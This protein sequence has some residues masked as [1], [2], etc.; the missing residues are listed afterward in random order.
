MNFDN[1]ARELI[2]QAGITVEK[3][4]ECLKDL[5]NLLKNKKN[6]D[7]IIYLSALILI[8]KDEINKSLSVE[9]TKEV[10]KS[11]LKLILERDFQSRIIFNLN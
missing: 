3:A 1:V 6:Y 8:I 7:A 11:L 5:D 2:K 10:V 4:E 9:E